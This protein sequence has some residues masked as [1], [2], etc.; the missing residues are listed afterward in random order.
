MKMSTRTIVTVGMF[1]AVLSVLSIMT[2]PL[3]SGVPITLQ[4]FG[5][6]LCGY[7]LGERKGT[8]SVLVYLL[9]GTMGLPVFSGMLGGPSRLFGYT[10]GFLWG[11]L[12]MTALCGIGIRQKKIAV[13]IAVSV[14]GLALCHLFGVLQFSV[15][16]SASL[17][18]AFVTASLPYIIKDVLSLAGAYAVAL[19]IRRALTVSNINSV[20]MTII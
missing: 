16:A 18:T 20:N 1:A 6:A 3:P 9:L 11:F 14:A 8:L 10:G 12:F 15:V 2:I 5:V 13:K 4:T 17:Q 7:V 19:P